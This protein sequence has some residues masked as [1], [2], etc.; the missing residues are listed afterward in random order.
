MNEHWKHCGIVRTYFWYTPERPTVRTVCPLCSTDAHCP[1]SVSVKAHL[2]R[3]LKQL[4]APPAQAESG[5]ECCFGLCLC[6]CHAPWSQEGTH[7][8]QVE[9]PRAESQNL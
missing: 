1:S 7:T 6:H 9:S 2:P 3:S 4:I 8:F 5:C